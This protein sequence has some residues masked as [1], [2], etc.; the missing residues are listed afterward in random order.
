MTDGQAVDSNSATA[1]AVAP[2]DPAVSVPAG[3]VETQGGQATAGQS[4]PTEEQFSNIDPKTL[5]PEL[6]GVY[7]N[8]QSD[9]TKKTQSV[10]DVR[11]KAEQFDQIS[12]DS[13]FVE[14]WSGL[15][16]QQKSDFKEQKA[17]V[18]KKIG[19]KITDDE[20]KKSFESKDAYLSM[21][22]RIA[23]H[24]LEK[25]QKKID[26]LEQFKSVTEASNIVEAFATEN[27]P[28][29]KP[30]RPD[31]YSLDEDGLING[32]LRLA[33]PEKGYSAEEYPAKLND[34]YSWAKTLSQKYYEKGRQD[35]LARIQQKA[36]TSTNPP[37][38]P[39][40]GAYTGP[41]PKKMS[42]RE[43]MDLAKKGIKV[44]QIYD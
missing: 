16:K 30:L 29:G 21:Q 17:A 28:D 4:A 27:G 6:Q 35:A 26:E 15:N 37:T 9:Y 7:K 43:A 32:F 1:T 20:F 44:P 19:E 11:K 10:A 34:A 2:S 23:Q 3:T 33:A 31:F 8:L 12:K 22:E 42:V 5:P 24:V 38:Q 39:A 25:S 14:Y 41:D 18:E 13:R 36:A 40:K